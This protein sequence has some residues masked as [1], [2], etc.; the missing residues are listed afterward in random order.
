MIQVRPAGE[1]DATTVA[2]LRNLAADT[3]REQR[4]GEALV[5]SLCAG[6]VVGWT[7]LA[8]VAGEPLGYLK[9]AVHGSRGVVAELW[10]DPEARGVGIGHALLLA[11]R[12]ALGDAGAI[13]IESAVLPGDRGT[14]NFFEAHAMTARLI[15]VSGTL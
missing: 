2:R 3:T 9:A 1:S 4:G 12:A 5:D 8:E 15:T 6:D 10:C 11:A 13:S 7:W 14:K